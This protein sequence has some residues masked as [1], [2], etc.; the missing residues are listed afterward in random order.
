DLELLHFERR[1]EEAH[2]CGVAARMA[3]A[4]DEPA[5]HGIDA[6]LEHDRDRRG[7]RPRRYRGDAVRGDRRDAAM[8]EVSGEPGQALVVILRPAELYLEILLGISSLLEALAKSVD[9]PGIH[10]GAAA[11]QE[12][13]HRHSLR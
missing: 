3:E 11:V 2:A 5:D 6:A 4:R 8:D 7:R 1:G 13:D 9:N 10:L 12:A